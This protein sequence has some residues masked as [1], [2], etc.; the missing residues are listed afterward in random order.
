MKMKKEKFDKIWLF[1]I[2][3]TFGFSLGVA[4]ATW[5]WFPPEEGRIFLLGSI[6]KIPLS[7]LNYIALLSPLVILLCYFVIR[8][9]EFENKHNNSSPVLK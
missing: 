4:I 6:A 5:D 3:L 1:F 8:R 2:G 7:F 9:R